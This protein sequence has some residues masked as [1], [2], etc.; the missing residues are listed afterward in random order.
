MMIVVYAANHYHHC[1]QYHLRGNAEAVCWIPVK[2]RS[3]FQWGGTTFART[4][5]RVPFPEIKDNI[6][7]HQHQHQHLEVV[8]EQ[9]C[10]SLVREGRQEHEQDSAW[11]ENW[12]I[13]DSIFI[14]R[15]DYHCWVIIH[16]GENCSLVSYKTW[17]DG[18]SMLD[19]IIAMIVN[20]LSQG[21]IGIVGL[22]ITLAKC[23]VAS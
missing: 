7:Q 8:F 4:A 18:W 16:C 22:S 20:A 12:S 21:R 9:A 14:T 5:W 15:L 6:H 2:T 17:H 11:H 10:F 13:L 1:Y 23:P 3:A 19:S